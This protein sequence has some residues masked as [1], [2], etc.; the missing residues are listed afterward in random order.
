MRSSLPVSVRRVNSNPP[1]P[2][3]A[4]QLRPAGAPLG[5]FDPPTE[6]LSASPHCAPKLSRIARA[7]SSVIL[8]RAGHPGIGVA[9]QVEQ[10]VA[11]AEGIDH[12][13]PDEEVER[14]GHGQQR[15]RDQP[16]GRAIGYSD[17]LAALT[18]QIGNTQRL[19]VGLI[20]HVSP[21]P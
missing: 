17:L 3:T 21:P 15:C 9:R 19:C 6:P 16:A 18:Q 4:A 11:G 14:A 20:E 2:A 1:G 8:A 12:P 10:Y 7:C 5:W 13:A